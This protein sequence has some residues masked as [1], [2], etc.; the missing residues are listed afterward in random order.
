[1]LNRTEW[2]D[3]PEPLRDAIR[4]RTGHILTAR[5]ASE[6]RNSALA[7]IVDTTDGTIFLKGIRNDHR[8]VVTQGREALI[9]PY[10]RP[11][12][13][14]LLWHLDDVAGWNV[15]AFEYIE[16]RHPS[17]AP[18]SPDL[19]AVVAAI[20]ALGALPCPA[21][22]IKDAARWRTYLDDHDT[23]VLAGDTLS[24]T[25]YNPA[26]LII[27]GDGSVRLID[28]AWPT[29]AAAWIDPCCLVLWLIA[30]GHTP[31]QAEEWAARTRAWASAPPASLD[32]FA[33]VNVRV[34]NEIAG[35]SA[36]QWKQRMAEAARQWADLRLAT[37]SR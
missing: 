4:A 28:W 6:G 14:A 32:V 2:L 19:P 15:L 9:N 31:V 8:G 7:A 23:A 30:S 36:D 18:D 3:L 27:T 26:N 1:M 35:N 13:P 12:A 11:V 21:I 10:V 16:G 34:W 24:H 37:V 25:D 5:T 29:R 22:P 20:D 33:R 17:Y